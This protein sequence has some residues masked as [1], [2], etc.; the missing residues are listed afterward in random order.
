[1]VVG[2]RFGMFWL[3]LW[4]E[5]VLRRIGVHKVQSFRRSGWVESD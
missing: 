5:R 1:M 2:G 3:V 4:V